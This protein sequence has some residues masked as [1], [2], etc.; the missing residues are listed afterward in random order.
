M[1]SIEWKPSISDGCFIMFYLKYAYQTE[2]QY[3][4]IKGYLGTTSLECKNDRPTILTSD[5]KSFHTEVSTALVLDG[6]DTTPFCYVQSLSWVF[7]GN[8]SMH[9]YI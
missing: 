3:K 9:V 7:M 5:Q 6:L 8:M 1:N 4:I 2:K